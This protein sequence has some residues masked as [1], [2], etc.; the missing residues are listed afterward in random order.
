MASR[1]DVLLSFETGIPLWAGWGIASVTVMLYEAMASPI[2]WANPLYGGSSVET[3]L[4]GFTMMLIW[5]VW[6]VAGA[7]GGWVP[8]RF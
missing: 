5:F 8:P 2:L 6:M 1:T 3:G 4:V 7:A